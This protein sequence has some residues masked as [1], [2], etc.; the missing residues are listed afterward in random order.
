[1]MKY[2]LV[3]FMGRNGFPIEDTENGGF[4]FDIEEGEG[5]ISHFATT[6]LGLTVESNSTMIDLLNNIP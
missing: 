3:M 4:E 5:S 6:E 1:M 2:I